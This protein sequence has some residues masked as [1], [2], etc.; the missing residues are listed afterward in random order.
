MEGSWSTGS[1]FPPGFRFHPTDQELI[2]HYLKKKVSSSLP[3]A[4]AIMA[5]DDHNNC[6]FVSEKA[7]FGEKEWF[8][9]SPRDRKYPNGVRPNRAAGSGYWKATGIDKPILAADGLQ[10][11][12]VKK[13][14]IFYLGRPPKGTKTEWAMH[15]YRLLD[16]ALPGQAMKTKHSMRLDDWVLCRIEKKGGGRQAEKDEAQVSLKLPQPANANAEQENQQQLKIEKSRIFEWSD[17]QHL[18]FLSTP[19]NEAI[20]KGGESD[21]R[22]DSRCSELEECFE[23]LQ[24]PPLLQFSAYGSMKRRSSFSSDI[25]ELM[26]QP[27]CKRQQC[28]SDEQYFLNEDV[29]FL[30]QSLTEFLR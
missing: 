8:F 11:I 22:S 25:D 17:A 2:T 7:L 28:S 9:F 3:P 4:W 30:D 1:H 14:L 29:F 27:P 18:D 10:C 6:C 24:Q 26:Q 5:D 15:E 21:S 23:V 19:E 20:S 16:S 12:G 13:A